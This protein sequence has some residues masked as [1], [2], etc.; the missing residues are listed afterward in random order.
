MANTVFV[1][2]VHYT[3]TSLWGEVIMI[4]GAMLY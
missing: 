3:A 2:K 1:T 4:H